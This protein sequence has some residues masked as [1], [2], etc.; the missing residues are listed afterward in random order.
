MFKFEQVS[1][2]HHQ[3]S[4]F[5]LGPEGGVHRSDVRGGGG[6]PPCL[7]SLEGIGPRSDLGGGGGVLPT[8]PFPRGTL[9]CDLFHDVF[10]VTPPQTDRR[11]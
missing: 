7:M 2:D 6:R 3:M 9:P 5:G 1:S 10:D 11:L 8:G 4:L